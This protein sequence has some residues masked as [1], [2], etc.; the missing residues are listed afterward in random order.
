[1]DRSPAST[2]SKAR[3]ERR[4]RR[5]STKKLLTQLTT[6]LERITALEH[7]KTALKHQNTV[8]TV[9]CFKADQQVRE[10]LAD[11]KRVQQDALDGES[12]IG[13]E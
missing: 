13:F 5:A 1:M 12:I 7:Q 8:L 3:K 2:Q 6:A 9:S 4:V 11:F 10:L